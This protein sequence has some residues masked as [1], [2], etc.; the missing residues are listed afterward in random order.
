MRLTRREGGGFRL[1]GAGV[2]VEG[3]PE[4]GSIVI[5]SGERSW[6]MRPNAS[7]S[8]AVGEPRDGAREDETLVITWPRDDASG[9][10]SVLLPDGQA[11]RVATAGLAH[12]TLEVSRWDGP[13]PYLA[14]RPHDAGWS[15]ELTPSGAAMDGSEEIVIATCFEIGRRDGW[16]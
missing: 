5:R 1:D 12:P 8:G 15:V 10:A 6:R 11:F 2:P 16:W 14:A 9:A 13:G 3:V 4:S 7:G